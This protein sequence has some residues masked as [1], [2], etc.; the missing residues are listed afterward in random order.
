MFANRLKSIH[1]RITWK[2]FLYR[3]YFQIVNIVPIFD[4]NYHTNSGF[5]I[6]DTGT[7]KG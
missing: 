3:F 7:Y 4:P 1:L 2:F 5:H 6:H